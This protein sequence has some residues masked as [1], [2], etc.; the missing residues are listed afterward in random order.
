[1][2]RAKPSGDHEDAGDPPEQRDDAARDRLAL[3]FRGQGPRLR[4]S[5]HELD[6]LLQERRDLE[7][8]IATTMI[9]ED[10]PEKRDTFLLKRGVYDAPD[11]AEKLFPSVPE[12]LGEMDPDL[13]KNRLGFAQWLVDPDHPLTARVRV[14]HYWQMYFG[15][16]LV[17][18]P[19]DFRHRASRRATPN[20]WTGS[21]CAFIET[22]W[23]VKA[24][25]T[26]S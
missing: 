3:A 24:M 19:E 25:H 1:M 10:M 18:T 5:R 9:M 13:P 14:N 2:I 20:C 4:A 17:T 11:T 16:G 12:R 23:D 8:A 15:K 6:S 7:G 22:G 26:S 21:P